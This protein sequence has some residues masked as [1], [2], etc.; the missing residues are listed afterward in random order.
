MLEEIPLSEEVLGGMLFLYEY[1]IIIL[2]DFGASHDFLSLACARKA[3]LTLYTIQVPYSISTP[4][5]RVIANRMTRKISLE[6]AGR[7]LLTA[8][9]IL[10]GQG[11][12]VI[13]GMNWIKMHWAILDISTRLIH[14]DSPIYGKVSL[15]LPPVAR[16][17]ASVYTVVVKSLDE[18]LVVREYLDVFP[19]DM[20]GMPPDRAIEFK[21]ELQSGIALVYKRSYPMA[22]NEMEELKIQL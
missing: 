17:Q 10:K 13:L 7:V 5:G 16:L 1:P 6:L 19:N 12:D 22:R 21:I 11:I 8:L 9:I 20:S 4:R 3:G 15:Q 2:F 14:L 18:I